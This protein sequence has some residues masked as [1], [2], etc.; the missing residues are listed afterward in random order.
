MRKKRPKQKSVITSSCDHSDFVCCSTVFRRVGLD[1][2]S[3]GK[4]CIGEDV[5][6]GV[7]SI[8]HSLLA[9]LGSFLCIRNREKKR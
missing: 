9:V 1:W 8:C 5:R 2:P 4:C 3:L 6:F 7:F